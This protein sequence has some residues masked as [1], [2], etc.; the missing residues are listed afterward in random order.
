[1]RRTTATALAA[2][3]AVL[4]AT[5]LAGADPITPPPDLPDDLPAS[6][7]DCPAVPHPTARQVC[8][9]AF[10]TA[11]L[12]YDLAQGHVERECHYA[13]EVPSAEVDV[14]V[15]IDVLVL[16]DG[17]DVAEA[18]DLFALAARAYRPLLMDLRA[19]IEPVALTATTQHG[20]LLEAREHVGGAVPEA[21]DL[22]YVLTEEPTA[23]WGS[24]FCIGGIKDP[25]LAFATSRP[26]RKDEAPFLGVPITPF[27][28]FVD[29]D[30]VT[31]AHEIGHLLGATHEQAN[32]AEGVAYDPLLP[33]TVMLTGTLD[34]MPKALRFSSAAAATVVGHAALWARP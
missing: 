6:Q 4:L 19:T 21:F 5:P 13:A 16:A 14:P 15:G 25:T 10:R 2:F 30:A 7:S 32:C 31:I 28:V 8:E 27:S 29:D 12:G 24:S 3:A 20:L 9:G 18:E 26:R 11:E 17:V 33:C 34:G 1:M 23:D 22:V